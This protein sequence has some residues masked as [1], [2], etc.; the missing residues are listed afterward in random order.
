MKF[1]LRCNLIHPKIDND[2]NKFI[3]RIL[4]SEVC[5]F[6]FKIKVNGHTVNQGC[7]P[8]NYIRTGIRALPFYNKNMYHDNYSF[9]LMK[10]DMKREKI[11]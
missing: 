5:F 11:A 10:C 2:R 3:F 1:P 9:L 7:L 4:F 6:M 8:G